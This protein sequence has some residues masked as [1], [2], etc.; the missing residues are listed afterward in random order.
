MRDE[1]IAELDEDWEKEVD[2]KYRAMVGL[3]TEDD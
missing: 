3:T 1:A 2:A